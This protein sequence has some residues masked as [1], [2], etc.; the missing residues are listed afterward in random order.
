MEL[1]NRSLQDLST[2]ETHPVWYVPA[3][4]ALAAVLDGIFWYLRSSLSGGL[5]SGGIST[6]WVGLILAGVL[7]AVVTAF[8]AIAVR[9][10]LSRAFKGT[11]GAPG[12]PGP[13]A[14]GAR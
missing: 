12:G 5:Q 7:A 1:R 2:P 6:T 14:Q 3:G 4:V 11:G 9:N 10:E 8:L 13:V